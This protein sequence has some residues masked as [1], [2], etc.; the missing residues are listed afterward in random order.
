MNKNRKKNA[1]S[2]SA[3][4]RASVGRGSVQHGRYKQQFSSKSSR[5]LWLKV[6]F[7][8]CRKLVIVHLPEMRLSWTEDAGGW[9]ELMGFLCVFV[10]VV[11][12]GKRL[13][14]ATPPWEACLVS[15]K[16]RAAAIKLVALHAG[17]GQ[18][19]MGI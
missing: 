18:K 12:P 7:F 5:V 1:S 9:G 19:K 10:V 17:W 11:N 3:V 2:L 4:E 15:D 6:V 16:R 14:C 8:N 13:V